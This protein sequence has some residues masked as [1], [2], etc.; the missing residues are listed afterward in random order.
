MPVVHRFE[1]CLQSVKIKLIRQCNVE[2]ENSL[3]LSAVVD[4]VLAG[5]L[6]V[7][8]EGGHDLIIFGQFDFFAARN[9]ILDLLSDVVQLPEEDIYA[10]LS[11]GYSWLARL[12]RLISLGWFFF[13]LRRLRLILL[14]FFFALAML[15]IGRVLLSSRLILVFVL[16]FLFLFV[17][18][19][20]LV[21]LDQK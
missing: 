21:S 18:I 4:K 11:L 12:L 10:D 19:D 1:I 17:F 16:F 14:L 8:L 20:L 9:S 5:Q 3:F 7:A 15:T 13:F 6:E 2:H